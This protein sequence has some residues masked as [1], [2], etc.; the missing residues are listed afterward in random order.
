MYLS[1][2]ISRIT[3]VDFDRE[4]CFG[5]PTLLGTFK[6]QLMFVQFMSELCHRV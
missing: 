2:S 1:L 6:Y 3:Q 5:I 4:R